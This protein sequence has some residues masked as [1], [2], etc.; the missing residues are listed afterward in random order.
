MVVYADTSNMEVMSYKIQPGSLKNASKKWCVFFRGITT[1]MSGGGQYPRDRPWDANN[2]KKD[3]LACFS[4]RWWWKTHQ[5]HELCV[6]FFWWI[7]NSGLRRVDQQQEAFSIEQLCFDK[8]KSSE[9]SRRWCS[10]PWKRADAQWSKLQGILLPSYM[11]IVRSHYKDL[12]VSGV[13]CQ[14]K[15]CGRNYPLTG[16][17][18]TINSR[19]ANALVIACSFQGEV[20]FKVIQPIADLW[21]FTPWQYLVERCDVRSLFHGP[22]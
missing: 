20:F 9:H 3:V 19:E 18:W 1:P 4:N 2:E 6:G 12:V 22:F 16:A 21:T 7:K 5:V 14:P 10:N 13:N 11:D 15:Q 8:K 17:G